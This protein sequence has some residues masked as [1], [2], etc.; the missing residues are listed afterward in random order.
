[1]SLSPQNQAPDITD[2]LDGS[3]TSWYDNVNNCLKSSECVPGN[4]EY[5]QAPSYGNQCPI[6]EGT[7]EFFSK[8]FKSIQIT[9]AIVSKNSLKLWASSKKW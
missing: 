7:L 1:M 5:A 4:Y 6:N 2:A 8:F 3:L 9:M